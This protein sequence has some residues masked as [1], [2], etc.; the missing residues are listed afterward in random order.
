MVS[1]TKSALKY[2]RSVLNWDSADRHKGADGM[3]AVR[4]TMIFCPN[5]VGSAKAVV[6]SDIATAVA[7]I[8][9]SKM[10]HL[11]C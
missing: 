4:D 2:C 11:L 10:K 7:K 6:V 3:F 1:E 8:N 5:I 9:L